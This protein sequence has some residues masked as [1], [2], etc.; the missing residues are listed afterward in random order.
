[1]LRLGGNLP[2]VAGLFGALS[3]AAMAGATVRAAS[4]VLRTRSVELVSGLLAA[5]LTDG[6]TAVPKGGSEKFRSV[7]RTQ[8]TCWRAG[9]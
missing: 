9:G 5:L 6:M 1:M 2:P 7:A 8:H 3:L 4:A